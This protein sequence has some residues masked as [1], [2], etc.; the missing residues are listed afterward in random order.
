MEAKKQVNAQ[1]TLEL[2]A[3]AINKL[4]ELLSC[5]LSQLHVDSS[6][7][8]IPYVEDHVLFVRDQLSGLAEGLRSGP[9]DKKPAVVVT[10]MKS[11]DTA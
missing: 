5:D 9:P 1:E 7:S 2:V 11:P 10:D 3:C 8:N 6:W 4:E